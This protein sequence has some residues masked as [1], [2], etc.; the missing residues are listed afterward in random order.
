MIFLLLIMLI[1]AF[2]CGNWIV[3]ELSDKHRF[4]KNKSKYAEFAYCCENEI[5]VFNS[6]C[7]VLVSAVTVIL[8]SITVARNITA[9]VSSSANEQLYKSLLYK[10]QTESIRDELG[11][12]N[13]EYIDEVQEWNVKLAK[14]RGYSD[15]V[16]IGVL[17]PSKAL[18]DIDFIELESIEIKESR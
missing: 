12:V 7:A 10:A 13:K 1:L 8:L 17:F 11:I 16:W 9:D 5:Q 3:G 15:N 4:G 14:F 18:G 6:V 2:I